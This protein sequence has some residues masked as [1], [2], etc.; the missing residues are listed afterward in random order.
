MLNSPFKWVGGKS[1][2]RKSIVALL[3]PH[4]CYVE[5]FAGAAWVLFGKPPSR[6]EV[7]N[8]IDQELITFFRVV[9]EKPDELISA[10]EWELV[11]RAE[12]ERLAILDPSKLTDVQRA[13]RF[14]YLIMAGW[15]GELNY[16]RFQ[17][18]ISDGGHGNRLIGALKHL[19]ERILPIH[20]RLRTVIIENLEWQE[21]ISR[22][23][24][25]GTVMYLDP[26]YPNNKC[27]YAHNMRGWDD[28]HRLAEHLQL[29]TCK[30]ILSSYDTAEIRQLFSNHTIMPVQSFS[31]MQ[32]KKNG[33][34][35][36]VNQEVL[37]TNFPPATHPDSA[38]A[39]PHQEPL[40]G[41]R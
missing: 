3:P 13:H 9:R 34:R 20:E 16:P 1:R 15:G 5:P 30:W 41:T 33:G 21:C 8:D 19:R 25:P 37:I 28:H 38:K 11:S 10:F 32:V 26:P 23:D 18:S 6:V 22:Y 35:R 40:P 12:F 39:K 27:N 24:R 7:L 36:I 31:G 2:L 17:T 4:S 29:T 14:Y